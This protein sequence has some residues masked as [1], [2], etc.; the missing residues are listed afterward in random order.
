[1][2]APARASANEGATMINAAIT[3]SQRIFFTSE[4]PCRT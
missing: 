4:H 1:V 2:P 3:A